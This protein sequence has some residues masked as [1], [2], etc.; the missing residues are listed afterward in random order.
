VESLKFSSL[1]SARSART[2]GSFPCT[3]EADD[4]TK[5]LQLPLSIIPS[6][7]GSSPEGNPVFQAFRTLVF[8]GLRIEK[9][10]YEFSKPAVGA[11]SVDIK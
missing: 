10:P 8:T 9:T 5:S 2:P 11:F 7:S 6:D 3:G 4:F 1:P